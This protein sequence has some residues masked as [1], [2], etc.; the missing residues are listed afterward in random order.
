MHYIDREI[1][2]ILDRCLIIQCPFV[3]RSHESV[4]FCF[5][6][7]LLL[8]VILVCSSRLF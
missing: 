3:E 5:V 6:I 2:F 8:L 7:E 4:L 1:G